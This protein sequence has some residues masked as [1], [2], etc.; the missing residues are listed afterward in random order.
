MRIEGTSPLPSLAVRRVEKP[1]PAS[2]FAGNAGR[3][4]AADGG[5]APCDAGERLSRSGTK[6]KIP[7]VV[8][9]LSAFAAQFLGQLMRAGRMHPAG[10]A[11]TYR[12]VAPAKAPSLLRTL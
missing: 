4:T 5:T 1:R 6:D 7:L 3:E 2:A 8:L 11:K 12:E 10:A 9:P